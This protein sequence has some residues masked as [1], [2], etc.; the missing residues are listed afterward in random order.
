MRR[1]DFLG[2]AGS[3]LGVVALALA[4]AGCSVMP[5]FDQTPDKPQSFGYK[6]SWF[7]VKASDPA[8][9]LDALGLEKGTPANW[10]SGL[11][12]ALPLPASQGSWV[13]VSPPVG[14][15]VLIV[16]RPSVLPYPVAP[17]ERFHDIGRKFDVLFSRL[18]K[19]FDDVQFFGSYRVV[20]FA[21]WARAQNGK[22][23]RVFAYADSEVLANVGEQT[24]EEAKLKF[25]N[26]RG[27]S[28]SAASDRIGEI[29]EQQ[30]AEE[31]TLVAKGLSRREAS[32]RIGQNGLR[33]FP[34][35]KDVVELAALWSIDPR[36]LSN[37]DHPLELGLATRLPVSLT[38]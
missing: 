28:P 23:K 18:M 14:N 25:A 21:A 22:P 13:F 16:S 3:G 11:A 38:Q 4:P 26:L 20:S 36:Q 2:A 19:R 7:A 6:V 8:L 35:E 29:A 34:D 37:Q 1:R 32:E 17:T 12:A 27:L 24:P 9:V 10:A 30:E 5:S 15:W 33:T 31:D